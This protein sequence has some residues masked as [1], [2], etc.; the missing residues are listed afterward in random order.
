ML[1]VQIYMFAEWYKPGCSLEYPVHGSG[2]IVDAL[3]RGLQKF[4]GRISSRSHVEIIVIEN[5]RATGFVRAKKAV[6]SNASMRDTLNLLPKEAVPK[7]YED[8]IKSTPQCDS[9]MH[10]HLG[11]D[12]EGIREDLGIHHIVVNDWDRGVDADQNV[13]LISIPSVLSPDLAPPG[14]HTLHA[15]CPG[16]EP[17]E[18]WEGLDRRSDDYKKLK[19]ERSEDIRLPFRGDSTFPGIGVPAVAAS[20]AIV[21]NSLVSVSQHSQLL[22]A[23]GK[24]LLFYRKQIVKDV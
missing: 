14:R 23:I 18:L 11:F 4:G 5:N 17:Y 1:F 15:Y 9:F 16:T 7:S 12:A 2:A 24:L 13:V 19:A 8:T 20:G 22:D 6:I 21:A 3:V 10:L